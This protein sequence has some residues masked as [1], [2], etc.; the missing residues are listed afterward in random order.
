MGDERAHEV[1]YFGLR[2]EWALVWIAQCC[3]FFGGVFEG[4][5]PRK[6]RC[7]GVT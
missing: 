2:L 1:E 5:I 3:G 6:R 4:H 7:K